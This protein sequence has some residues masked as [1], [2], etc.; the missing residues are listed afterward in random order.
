MCGIIGFYKHNFTEKD[1]EF[2]RKTI[3]YLLS[4]TDVRGKD[5]SGLQIK[6]DQQKHL[7]KRNFQ[8]SKLIKD[9]DYKTMMAQSMASDS[10]FLSA[11]GHCRMQT[12]GSYDF[13]YNNQPTVK[14]DTVCI[15]NGIITNIEPLWD[16]YKKYKRA[17]DIDT[18]LI[19]DFFNEKRE[20]DYKYSDIISEIYS[21][22]YG[23]T[24]FGI[25]PAKHDDLII[26]TNTGSS[27][28]LLDETQKMLILSSENFILKNYKAKYAEKVEHLK[29]KQLKP[30]QCIIID[31]QSGDIEVST[32]KKVK[33][34]PTPSTVDFTLD[35]NTKMIEKNNINVET[36]LTDEEMALLK[37][38]EQA[39]R[40][41]KRCSK[42]LLPE[43]FPF[44]EYD[45]DGVC[46]Y[47]HNYEKIEVEPK[48]ALEEIM[49]K[50][51]ASKNGKFLLTF[52]GG[53]DSCYGM[54]LLKEMD[55]D[56]LSYTYDWGMVTDL[57]RR[58]QS[59]LCGKLGVEHIIVSADID[60][61]RHNVKKNVEAWLKRPSLGIVPLFMA[62]DKQFFY[63]ANKVGKD[64]GI[65][66]LVILCDNPLEVTYFKFG[67]A[68]AKPNFIKTK[69]MFTL[70]L[71]SYLKMLFYYFKEFLMNPRLL[72]ASFFDTIKG[73]LSYYAIPHN[74]INLFKYIYW[75]EKQIDKILLE[76]YDW[77]LAPDAKTTWRIGDGTAPFYNYIYTSVAG[78]S[79]NDTFRS[80]Q[81]REG[82][83]TREEALEL[84][85]RDNRPRYE[86]IKWYLDA[87]GIDFKYAIKTVNNIKK[88]Y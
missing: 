17:Y 67:F 43:S 47:C 83:M 72:N 68:G 50:A 23:E 84:V 46:N 75:E 15:H 28:Y 34:T 71:A 87:I 22:V 78:F 4:V 63:Y 6:T 11:M 7:I 61:K 14:E 56:F 57:A 18:E 30:G 24:T 66:D 39:L 21:K 33:A 45:K 3:D 64:N 55:A 16:E 62:G 8:S 48:E 82:V 86:S 69:Q 41:L 42:C 52:S 49:E 38:D 10:H 19:C 80:N 36:H 85:I 79:E 51:K 58:N 60:K 26:A 20:G 59:R 70:N 2:A 27:Y 81:I 13:E 29:I 76:K 44:I 73:F 5:T 65:N 25:M 35:V 54:H 40:D 32:F 12:N 37:Y 74:Y 9:A 53:R 1:K 77:E 31:E 88:R